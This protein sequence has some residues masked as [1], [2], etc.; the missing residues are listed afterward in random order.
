VAAAYWIREQ[1]TP[2]EWK[3][4]REATAERQSA[5]LAQA[6]ERL[7]DLQA[8]KAHLPETSVAS[9]RT[10]AQRIL[11]AAG[12]SAS[13]RV[14]VRRS[15][16]D[17]LP[18]IRLEPRVPLSTLYNWLLGHQYLGGLSLLVA[19]LHCGFK[20]RSPI[21]AA[22]MCLLILVVLSGLVGTIIYALVPEKLTA[23]EGV[24]RD[25]GAQ[26]AAQNTPHHA[27][28]EGA[29]KVWLYVHVPLTVALL[30]IVL[31]HVL[32]VFYY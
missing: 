10:A 23:L 16:E 4:P 20:V 19:G 5:A 7:A 11:K 6:R 8:E 9:L 29:L 3:A 28:Y 21:G 15:E 17:S 12:L 25:Q 22:A 31:I 32:A 18:R 13:Y 24:P 1:H 27:R 14:T 30:S 26:Q 2:A